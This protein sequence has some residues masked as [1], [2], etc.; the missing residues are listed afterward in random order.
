MAIPIRQSTASQ[1]VP[2][3]YFL[4]STDGNTEETALTISNTDIKLWKHGATTLANKNSGG[5]THMSNGIYYAVLDATDSN[6]LGALIIFVHESGALPVKVECE[7]MTANRYDSLVAGTDK[8]QVDATEI[9][10]DS[11]AADNLEL[12]YDGTGY[13][14]TNSTIGTCTTNTDMR[15]TD[16]AALAATA[17]TDVTWTDA[18]AGYLDAA[19]TSRN[20]T[21]PPTVG[22]IREEIDSNSTRLDVDVSTRSTVTTAQVNTEVVDVLKTD[23]TSEMSQGAP[24]A[25][26]TMEEMMAYLYFRLRNKCTTTADE[27]AMWDDLG[28]TKLVKATI[29]DNGTTLTKGE[30]VSG[31]P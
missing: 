24:P 8:L 12:D 7:V 2:L 4:D 10:G 29:T 31:A 30:Y 23:T 22:E 17:L 26:P 9:S 11:T 28:T 5:A 19:I 6:T 15:G 27:D 13:T 14:K 16:S 3:G 20:A 21:T 25:T 18:K 1:A